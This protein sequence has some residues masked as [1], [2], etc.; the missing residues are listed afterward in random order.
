MPENSVKRR[1]FWERI[2]VNTARS[3]LKYGSDRVFRS[4]SPDFP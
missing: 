2:E 3:L 1:L 4:R